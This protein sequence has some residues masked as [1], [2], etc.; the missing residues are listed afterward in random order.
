MDRL[1][2]PVDVDGRTKAV[3][4]ES[5][6]INMLMDR[7]IPV[8][9]FVLF[10]VDRVNIINRLEV[11]SKSCVLVGLTNEHC[12]MLEWY[13]MLEAWSTIWSG[14]SWFGP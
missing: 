11:K 12:M 1:L 2:N 4:A 7:R 6:A 10:L 8:N 9:M 13:D 14:Q 3:T 5:F